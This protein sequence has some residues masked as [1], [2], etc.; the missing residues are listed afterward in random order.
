MFSR[1]A[2]CVAFNSFTILITFASSSVIGCGVDAS[3]NMIVLFGGFVTRSV[4]SS[5]VVGAAVDLLVL[6]GTDGEDVTFPVKK[7]KKKKKNQN[8]A[9]YKLVVS[10]N[11]QT[12]IL[13]F[14]YSIYF[15]TIENT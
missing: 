12:Y 15:S 1:F 3:G 5:V 9:C 6:T 7:K 11:N 10:I 14:T 4:G 13:K 2:C 8:P